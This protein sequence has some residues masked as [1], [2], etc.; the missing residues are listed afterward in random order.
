MIEKHLEF[1]GIRLSHLIDYLMELEAVQTSHD[2]PLLFQGSNW[3]AEILKEEE[4][5]ITSTFRV[6]AVHICFKAKTSA[7]LENVIANYRKKTTRA[8]G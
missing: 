6:N 3:S 5:T 1:R 2:F 4:L 7:A 8:G